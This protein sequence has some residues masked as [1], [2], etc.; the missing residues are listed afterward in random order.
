MIDGVTSLVNGQ[1]HTSENQ[2]WCVLMRKGINRKITMILIPTLCPKGITL[3]PGKLG[4]L[5]A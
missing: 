5:A 2:Q 4:V 3:H 1:E